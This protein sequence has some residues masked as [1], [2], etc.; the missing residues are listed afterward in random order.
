[1]TDKNKALIVVV[2][3]HSGSM[4][5]IQGDMVGGFKT[6]MEEQKALPGICEVSL[7]QFDDRYETV[8]EQ[9]PIGEVPKLVLEPRGS[10]A[11]WDALGRSIINVGMG[12]SKLPEE[13]RPGAVVVLVITDGQ[14]NASQEFTAPRVREMIKVQQSDY[15]WKFAYLGAS[16]SSFNDAQHLGIATAGQYVASAAGVNQLYAATS[17]G[18][19]SYR[20]SIQRG[21]SNAALDIDLKDKK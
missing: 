9:K 20:D 5:K 2:L 19:G 10:T 13:Q 1:M 21:V 8:Y 18:V 4:E 11:L 3:D 14:E 7:Y 16:E 6:F 15:Q 12:L 17:K